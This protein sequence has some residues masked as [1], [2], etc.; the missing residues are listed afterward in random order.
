MAVGAEENDIVRVC[1]ESP[2]SEEAMF[3][4]SKELK[5]HVSIIYVYSINQETRYQPRMLLW[6]DM[7]K[8]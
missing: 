8:V 5:N 1:R 4:E 7:A 3:L 6:D 2:S